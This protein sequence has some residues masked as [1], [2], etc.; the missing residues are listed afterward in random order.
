[1]ITRDQFNRYKEVRDSGV[2]NMFNVELVSQLA[3]LT[4][5]QC[6]EIMRYYGKI[7]KAFSES[8]PVNPELPDRDIKEE[9]YDCPIHGT[10][11]GSDC[12]RC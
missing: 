12:P 2:T 11:E 6:F 7:E 8:Q 5:N 3:W 10:G 1:M 9:N 4:K